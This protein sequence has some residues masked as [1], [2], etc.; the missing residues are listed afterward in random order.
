MISVRANDGLVRIITRTCAIQSEKGSLHAQNKNKS[1]EPL[2]RVLA[3]EGADEANIMKTNSIINRLLRRSQVAIGTIPALGAYFAIIAAL[4]YAN[5]CRAAPGGGDKIII[6]EMTEIAGG[7]VATWARVNGAGK[8][9]W[10]GLT[11]P[12][13]MAENMPSRGSPR[14]S[15]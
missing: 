5:V 11:V 7:T 13:S 4:A 15:C 8:V 6:G 12:L 9:I 14:S 10:V 3:H 2:C 1:C